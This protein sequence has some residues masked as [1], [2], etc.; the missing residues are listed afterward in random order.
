MWGTGPACWYLLFE[1]WYL[2]LSYL[3]LL[4]VSPV[5]GT[6]PAVLRFYSDAVLEKRPGQESRLR[7]WL[8]VISLWMNFS[9]YYYYYYYY[10]YYFA[11]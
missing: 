6:S 8:L 7:K 11:F 9:T 1:Y 3:L 10:Y 4:V 5:M 2:G